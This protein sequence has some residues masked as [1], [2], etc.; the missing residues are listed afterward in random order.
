ME[1]PD[2][3]SVISPSNR[4][5]V[6][7][8]DHPAVVVGPAVEGDRQT[9]VAVVLDDPAEDPILRDIMLHPGPRRRAGPW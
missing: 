9:A 8:L 6:D 4:F 1:W 3:A 2:S 5:G 7:P